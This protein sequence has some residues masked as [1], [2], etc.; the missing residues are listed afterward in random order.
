MENEMATT[1]A[2]GTSVAVDRSEAE[3]RA[4]LRRYGATG[5]IIGES[6]GRAQIA[7]EMHDRRV[8]MRLVLPER[9]EKRF[10]QTAAR[11]TTRSPE[12]ALQLW[13][14]ACREKWRSLVLALK[15][16]LEAVQSG[17]ETF[18]QAFMAHIMLPSGDTI[19]EWASREENQRA[20]FSANHPPLLPGAAA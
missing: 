15:A 18:D 13:E 14:Q 20:L 10:H 1:Y 8:I 11:R 4:L 12:V 16:K 5:F 19:G 3:I 7:F 2:K 6:M 17:I 9:S